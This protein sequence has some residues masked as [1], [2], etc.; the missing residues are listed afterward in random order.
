[1]SLVMF[2]SKA[3]DALIGRSFNGYRVT[4]FI[5]RDRMGVVFE[6]IQEPLGQPVA[7]KLLYCQPRD[8]PFPERFEREARALTSLKHPNIVRLLDFGSDGPLQY[9]VMELID[10]ESL[11]ERLAAVH[12]AE[13]G[14]TADLIISI[15]QQVGSALFYA[16]RSGYVHGDLNSGNILLANDGRVLLSEFG[17]ARAL[18]RTTGSRE[19]VGIP[20]YL[21]PEQ[22]RGE[23]GITPLADLYS[24]AIV[25]YEITVG[26]V[27]FLARTPAAV[28]RM[29]RTQPPPPPSSLLPGFPSE[30]EAVLTRALAKN[31]AERYESVDAFLGSFMAAMG[32]TLCPAADPPPADTATPPTANSVGAIPETT[33]VASE[34]DTPAPHDRTARGVMAPAIAAARSHRAAVLAGS[35]LALI[36]AVVLMFTPIL[37]TSPT[38]GPGSQTSSPPSPGASAP[39]VSPSVPVESSAPPSQPP[40]VAPPAPSPAP[41]PPPPAVVQTQ[42]AEPPAVAPPPPSTPPQPHVESPPSPAPS[43]PPPTEAVM[44]FYQLIDQ[45]QFDQA[46]GLW[47]PRMR[48]TYPPAQNITERFRNTQEITVQHAQVSASGEAAE[49][50]T[51]SV[52]LLEVVGSPSATRH[53]VGTWQLVRGPDGWLLDQPNLQ[54]E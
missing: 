28:M 29:Q 4:R 30:V 38:P 17:V 46:A 16:H 1:M 40:F 3:I 22:T 5:A 14:F 34:R 44:R 33:A 2:D 12:A 23:A 43:P 21:A 45:H 31:P 53:W 15:V 20:E 49:R 54:Q 37:A 13:S 51:V 9:F 39:G 10:G 35:T 36:I 18:R 8:Q 42:P 25:T 7:I 6:G 19:I 32:P 27:P 41:S 47:T 48:A 26:R 50:A 24:L 52:A 11:K